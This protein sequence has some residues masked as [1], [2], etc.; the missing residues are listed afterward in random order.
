M[1]TDLLLKYNTQNKRNWT[2][3]PLTLCTQPTTLWT[4]SN[5]LNAEHEVVIDNYKKWREKKSTTK[6]ERNEKKYERNGF[7]GRANIN[8]AWRTKE[9]QRKRWTT[10]KVERKDLQS[11]ETNETSTWQREKDQKKRKKNTILALITLYFCWILITSEWWE[12]LM[13]VI[14]VARSSESIYSLLIIITD[15]HNHS[16]SLTYSVTPHTH[17]KHINEKKVLMII[18]LFI[19][20]WK[21]FSTSYFIS[22]LLS[23]HTHTQ[24]NR[25]AEWKVCMSCPNNEQDWSG[26]I[27]L[28][29]ERSRARSHFHQPVKNCIPFSRTCHAF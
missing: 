27:R 4:L 28:E 8:A 6:N 3:S 17:I 14:A 18:G 13:D 11:R 2:P 20:H 23:T 25:C 9:T 12:V 10:K 19:M 21:N 5:E 7:C 29:R 22:W 24:Y 15:P 1:D 16:L 26:R